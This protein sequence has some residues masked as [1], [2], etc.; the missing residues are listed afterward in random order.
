MSSSLDL[1]RHVSSQAE[2]WHAERSVM[3]GGGGGGGSSTSNA[4][5]LDYDITQ[6]DIVRMTRIASRHLDVHSILQLPTVTYQA[7]SRQDEGP[8]EE[9]PESAAERQNNQ[10]PMEDVVEQQDCQHGTEWSWMMVQREDSCSESDSSSVEQ[11]QE[12]GSVSEIEQEQA[13]C[14]ICLEHFQTGERLRVLPCRH[15]FHVGCIDRWLSGSHSFDDCYT[16]GCP[17]CK[18]RPDFLPSPADEASGS[19]PSWAFAAIGET[20][21]ARDSGHF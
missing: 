2:A 16:T 8:E 13:V 11:E 1:G 5:R 15:S 4:R 17:T 21:A 9:E 14:V 7:E 6:M 19:V 3:E 10:A 20:L 18:K 12:K